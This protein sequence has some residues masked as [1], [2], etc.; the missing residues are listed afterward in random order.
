MAGG[1]PKDKRRV[2]LDEVPVRGGRPERPET[3]A[4]TPV[5]SS[6]EAG[7]DAERRSA[8]KEERVMPAFDDME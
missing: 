8:D 6:A 7:C 2:V 1:P 4:I 5:T 3:V